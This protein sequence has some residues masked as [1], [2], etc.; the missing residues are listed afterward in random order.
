MTLSI[1]YPLNT[2]MVPLRVGALKR[3]PQRVRIGGWQHVVVNGFESGW[4]REIIIGCV[5]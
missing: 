3:I 4:F 2:D 5:F 1:R